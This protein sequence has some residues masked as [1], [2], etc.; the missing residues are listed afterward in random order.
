M[1]TRVR[2][3]IRGRPQWR[4]CEVSIGLPLISDEYYS[5]SLEY[6][7]IERCLWSIVRILSVD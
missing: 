6:Q 1:S 3:G 7:L 5:V 2:C 4:V